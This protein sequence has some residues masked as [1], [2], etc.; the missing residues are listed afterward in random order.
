MKSSGDTPSRGGHGMLF[1]Y[2]NVW[3]L[4]FGCIL[5]W[6]CFV[7]AG[8]TFLPVAGPLGTAVAMVLSAAVMLV[9]AANYHFMI[10]RHPGDGGSFDYA[11]QL[12]RWIKCARRSPA[13]T[14]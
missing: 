8:S 5:G 11:K 9:I 1:R 7:M 12:L 2:M 6:G 4:S 10:D 14:A 3:A 13:T